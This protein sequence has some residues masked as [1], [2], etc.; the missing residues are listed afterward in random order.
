MIVHHIYTPHPQLTITF[1]PPPGGWQE[2]SR[3][4][5][6]SCLSLPTPEEE[7]SPSSPD[8][9]SVPATPILPFL[10]VGSARDAADTDRLRTMGIQYVLNVTSQVPGCGD[11]QGFN[12]LR[13]PAMDSHQQ[14]LK[15]YF[16]RAF[17]F[18]GKGLVVW[19][20]FVCQLGVSYFGEISLVSYLDQFGYRIPFL[21]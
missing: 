11:E 21:L 14:N 8:L 19:W 13:L 3:S 9:A 5:L 1:F 17:A 7:E 12:F 16:N 6:D 15:Q 2:F 20:C 18:I 10:Y 4:Q